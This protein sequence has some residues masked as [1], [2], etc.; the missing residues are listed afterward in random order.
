VDIA[1]F[2]AGYPPFDSLDP[3]FLAELAGRAQIEFSPAGSVILEHEG[4]PSKFAYVVRTGAVELVDN[5][6]VIDELGPGEMFGHPSMLAGSEPTFTVR[7]REDS[8][9]YLIDASAMR[10]VLASRA[11]LAFVSA[12]LRD[13]IGHA[14]ASPGVERVDPW[15]TPVGSLVRRAPISCAPET[16]V[17]E[18]A[19]RMAAAKV[20][21]LLVWLERGLGI[22]TDRDL[23][24]RIIAEGR[25]T[26][27]PIGEIASFPVVTIGEDASAAD[28]LAVMLERGVHH[29]PVRNA[30]DEVVG[31]VT[32]TDLLGL[33]RRR[34]F[35]LRSAVERAADEGEVIAAARE[36]PF[37][38][39][40]LVGAHVD[41]VDI[42]RVVGVAADAL[43]VRLLE[44]AVSELGEPPVPWAWLA[45]GSQAR[46]EQ[47]LRTDQDHAIAFEGPDENDV[48]GYFAQLAERVTAGLE[49]AGI[50]RC[51][52]GV[53]AT[54]RPWRRSL[55][56]W[57]DQFSRWVADVGPGGAVFTAIAFDF[58][59]VAGPLDAE[60][61]LRRPVHGAA[62]HPAFLRHLA[63]QAVALRPPT[64]FLR[65]FVV[66]A[67]GEHAGRLDIKH[68]GL[69]AITSV[70]RLIALG[71]GVADVR[72][73]DRLRAAS[74]AGAL[75]EEDREALEE[76]FRL[77]W[78]IRLEHQVE[79]AARGVPPDDFV[80]P[81]E[82]GPVTRQGLKAAFRAVDRAQRSL[83][84]R[85]GVAP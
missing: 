11:G 37:A 63:A 53:S 13:R 38:V 78:Q 75:D 55:E 26:G 72:T 81:K 31:V 18:A 66:E 14:L 40:G 58:R 57:V 2:L 46:H 77:L 20:S 50:P 67:R 42:G 49:A 65:D 59:R 10:D 43:S 22:V 15:R 79:Q 64:G 19:R 36:L 29:L 82:L 3:I 47:A 48:D 17:R 5:D 71:A 70:A 4:E 9:C 56:S 34:P 6:R 28:A 33:E 44:L 41:P 7:A 69:T 12:S 76:A 85:F 35:A 83:A 54:E 8:L 1:A 51:T 61:A 24:S 25:P 27:R 39:R 80:D 74:A 23:R 68:G 21:S 16:Q 45:L 52:A 62:R 60:P 73:L 32:D 84:L 30:A